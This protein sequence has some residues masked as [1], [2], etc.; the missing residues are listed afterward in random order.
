MNSATTLVLAVTVREGEPTMLEAVRV[1]SDPMNKFDVMVSSDSWVILDV[2][3]VPAI[4]R[5]D[6]PPGGGA[7]VSAV[8]VNP[9]AITRFELIVMGEAP[10]MLDAVKVPVIHVFPTT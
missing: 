9:E 10:T 7:M 4:L 2:V 5:L 3:I 6:S 1:L 8:S